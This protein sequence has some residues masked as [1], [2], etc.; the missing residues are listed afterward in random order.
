MLI[1]PVGLFIMIS[2]LLFDAY[3]Y[4]RSTAEPDETMNIEIS[5]V[6]GY[7]LFKNISLRLLA[8]N[9]TPPFALTTGAFASVAC[10]ALYELEDLSIQVC[11]FVEA[12]GFVPVPLISR[13]SYQSC[14]PEIVDIL[15]DP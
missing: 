5:A 12:D 1:L 6:I 2:V 11:T 9:V 10:V 7:G 8:E 4:V 14:N 3:K 15:Y 13:P